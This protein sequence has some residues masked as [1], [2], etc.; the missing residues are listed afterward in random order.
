MKAEPKRGRGR[1]RLAEDVARVTVVLP[2]HLVA[3]IEEDAR[4]TE[5]NRGEWLRRAAFAY[6]GTDRERGRF[7]QRCEA[8]TP[9]D[10]NSECVPCAARDLVDA[11]ER[12]LRRAR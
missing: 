6:L 11:E 7:C 10:A 12:A 5:I 1:P 9:H 3:M 8:V 2:V 4:R